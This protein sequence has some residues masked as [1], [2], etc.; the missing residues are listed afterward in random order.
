MRL[1]DICICAATLALLLGCEREEKRTNVDKPQPSAEAEGPAL[2]PALA[3]ALAAAT[4]PPAPAAAAGQDGPPP[5]GI[6]APG[7]A[8]RQAAVGAPPKIT[9][10]GTGTEPRVRLTPG[11]GTPQKPLAARITVA[12]QAAPN[13]PALPVQFDVDF[14][15]EKADDAS[16]VRKVTGKIVAAAV[17]AG[18]RVPPDLDAGVKKL[19]GSSLHFEL[20]P[21]GGAT[22]FRHEGAAGVQPE[23][24]DLV[25]ALRDSVATVAVPFPGEAVGS[26][27]F[28]MVTSRDGMLGQDLVSYRMVR[29]ES[30]KPEGVT[31]NLST[32]RYA[33]RT[34]FS[35]DG[36]QGNFTLDEFLSTGD[37]T[38]EYPSGT[39]LPT[40]GVLQSAL[41][42]SVIPAQQPDQRGTLQLAL[43]AEFAARSPAQ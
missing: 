27:A 1:S 9:L 29:V 34:A 28:W 32:K 41:A 17:G 11:F 30:V 15:A 20:Q 23:L 12:L 37:G 14:S 35:M 36:L 6:F 38:L 33:T 7:A 22:G 19:R 39:S 43:Q 31:L 26:G 13:Q 18:L 24:L 16:E 3:S 8:D 2:D 21:N 42:A 25:R 4:Q 5:R 10:G 40:S